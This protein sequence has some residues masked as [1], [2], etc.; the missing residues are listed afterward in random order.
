MQIFGSSLICPRAQTCCAELRRLARLANSP[1]F[2][3]VRCLRWRIKFSLER[4]L[5]PPCFCVRNQPLQNSAGRVQQALRLSHALRL[6]MGNQCRKTTLVAHF[7]GST[8]QCLRESVCVPSR[9][10]VLSG[11]F[12]RRP[13]ALAIKFR[14]S[15]RVGR[16]GLSEPREDFSRLPTKCCS[17]P[18]L[19]PWLISVT[20]LFACPAVGKFSRASSA[21][22][23]RHLQLNFV[24]QIVSVAED[25]LSPE[26]TIHGCPQNAARIRGSNPWLYP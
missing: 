20:N 22:E 15:D 1:G 6:E 18:W 19:Y 8:L 26:R 13:T 5:N 7:R 12:R 2:K 16:R 25:C 4:F 17:N 21:G 23:R 10:K 9:W 24:N 14:K 11:E 3:S